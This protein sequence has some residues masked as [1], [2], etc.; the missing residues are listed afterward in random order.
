MQTT[1]SKVAASILNRPEEI[2]VGGLLYKVYPPTASTIILASEAIAR[3]PDVM[4]QR[5]AKGDTEEELAIDKQRS[6]EEVL[7]ESFRVAKDCRILGEIVAILMLGEQGL[8][9]PA[10]RKKRYFFGLIC[11]RV[12]ID[13]KAELAKALLKYKENRELAELTTRLIGTSQLSDFF[14]LTVSLAGINI[15]KPTVETV[16]MTAY[17]Q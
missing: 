9:E 14:S 17:G 2:E 15:L 13:R 10:Y 12:K 3:M 8:E 4:P 1:E 5:K 6:F 11:R 16:E 7:S